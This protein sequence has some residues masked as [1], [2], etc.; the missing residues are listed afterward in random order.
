MQLVQSPVHSD[1]QRRD[2]GSQETNADQAFIMSFNTELAQAQRDALKALREVMAETADPA[3]DDNT[4]LDDDDLQTRAARFRRLSLRLRAATAILRVKPIT[5]PHSPASDTKPTLSAST[6]RR[7]TQAPSEPLNKA[8]DKPHA[9]NTKSNPEAP[10]SHPHHAINPQPRAADSPHHR[11][12]HT[13]QPPQR[14]QV[15]AP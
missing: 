7:S 6:T 5:D 11:N 9:P 10:G 3:E 13:G 2:A 15:S 1:A 4:R 14:P 8:P 12:G